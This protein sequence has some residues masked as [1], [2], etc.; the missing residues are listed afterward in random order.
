MKPDVNSKQKVN[1]DLLPTSLYLF[2]VTLFS[3]CISLLTSLE[4]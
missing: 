3:F 4:L 1:L 2:I